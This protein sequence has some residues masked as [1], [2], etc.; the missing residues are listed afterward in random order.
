MHVPATLVPVKTLWLLIRRTAQ[1][2]GS[3]N[4]SH[5]AAAI[6]YYVLFSVVP[7]TIFTVSI[8]GIVV[9]DQSLQQDVAN[10][11]VD[12]LNVERGVPVVE[13]NRDAIV[14]K[15]GTK[16]LEE[17]AAALAKLP[18]PDAEALAATIDQG[19]TVNV[20]GWTQGKNELTASRSTS[21]GTPMCTARSSSRS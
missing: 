17:I 19:G 10:G 11:I 16:A 8:F 14:T 4:C 2:Y 12:F 5:M 20:A 6:S 15:Y 9:R 1:E 18:D 3:D 7:L 21:L 13:P